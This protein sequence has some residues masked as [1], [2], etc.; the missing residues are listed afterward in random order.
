MHL[1]V[2]AQRLVMTDAFHRCADRFLVINFSLVEF[3]VQ[4]KPAGD[5]LF[6]DF[7]LNAAHDLNADFLSRCVKLQMQLGIFLL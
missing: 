6:Q 4:V 3:H 7:N 1:G 2:M 5:Q